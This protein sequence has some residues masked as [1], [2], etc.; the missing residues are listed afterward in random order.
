M[1]YE[2]WGAPDRTSLLFTGADEIEDCKRQNMIEPE[3]EFI[4]AIEADSDNEAMTSYH[5]HM[6]WEPYRPMDENLDNRPR[7]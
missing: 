2:L 6:G 1:R 7:V 4:R 3:S 5:E